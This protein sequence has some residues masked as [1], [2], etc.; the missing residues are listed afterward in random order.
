M[1]GLTSASNLELHLP[2]NLSMYLYML[3]WKGTVQYGSVLVVTP[4]LSSMLL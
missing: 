3:L 2:V 4:I 1:H